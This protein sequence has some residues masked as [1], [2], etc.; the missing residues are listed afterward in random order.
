MPALPDALV[1]HRDVQQL[2]HVV[3]CLLGRHLSQRATREPSL[4]VGSVVA[5]LAARE[6]GFA[7]SA[8]D[9]MKVSADRPNSY[10]GL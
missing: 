10:G 8:G 7:S 5:Q 2:G 6:S 9:M 4:D 1:R 3:G